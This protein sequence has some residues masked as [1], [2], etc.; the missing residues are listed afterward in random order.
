MLAIRELY[1]ASSASCSD[2]E[3]RA[4]CGASPVG[5]VVDTVV[6]FVNRCL[7]VAGSRA[8]ELEGAFGEELPDT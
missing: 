2:S 6:D 8:I 7:F 3:L 5:P 1:L 4:L